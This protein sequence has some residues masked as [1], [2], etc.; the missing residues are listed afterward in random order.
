MFSIDKDIGNDYPNA[1]FQVKAGTFATDLSEG[2]GF[3]QNDWGYNGQASA[4]DFNEAMWAYIQENCLQDGQYVVTI[5][6]FNSLSTS[7]PYLDDNGS[8]VEFQ[9]YVTQSY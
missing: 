1:F 9:V 8:P 4:G 3:A 2:C 6:L 7:D 5:K